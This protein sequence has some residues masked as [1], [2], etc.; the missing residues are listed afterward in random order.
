MNG[1]SS[2]GFS[3][4]YGGLM[5]FFFPLRILG[6]RWGGRGRIFGLGTLL[7][8]RSFWEGG[9]EWGMGRLMEGEY[10]V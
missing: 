10:G 2:P 1:D 9:A 3:Y 7:L 5:C 4:G 8:L 6:L